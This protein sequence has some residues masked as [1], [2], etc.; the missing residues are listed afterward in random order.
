MER[1]RH[2][3]K[4]ELSTLQSNTNSLECIR[5]QISF[6]CLFRHIYS[7]SRDDLQTMRTIY[8]FEV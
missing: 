4:L 5:N 7:L 6:P 2:K 8:G 3:Y 1:Q